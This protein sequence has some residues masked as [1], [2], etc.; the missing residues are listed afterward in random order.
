[1]DEISWDFEFK[2]IIG[3]AVWQAVYMFTNGA[4]TDRLCKS[5]ILKNWKIQVCGP[6]INLSMIVSK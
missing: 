5:F 6:C 3:H 4:K 2:I 1:M